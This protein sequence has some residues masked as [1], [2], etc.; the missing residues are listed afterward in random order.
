MTRYSSNQTIYNHFLEY[1]RGLAGEYQRS[2]NPVLKEFLDNLQSKMHNKN[3]NKE[4][5][6]MVRALTIEQIE[7]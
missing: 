3:P 1:F 4:L 7:N 6:E 2:F 5:E